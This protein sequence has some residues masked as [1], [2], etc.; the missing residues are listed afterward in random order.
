M[1]IIMQLQQYDLAAC[2]HP[3]NLLLMREISLKIKVQGQEE[4]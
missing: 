4:Y 1:A 3:L 2:Q